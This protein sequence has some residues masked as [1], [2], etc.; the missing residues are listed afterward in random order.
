MRIIVE[1]R[2]Q[3]V[4]LTAPSGPAGEKR[5]FMSPVQNEGCCGFLQGEATRLQPVLNEYVM[6]KTELLV[7]RFHII[8][9]NG[10]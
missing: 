3:G 1:H 10:G 2:V 9:I 6:L 8:N 4:R 7:R 5:D